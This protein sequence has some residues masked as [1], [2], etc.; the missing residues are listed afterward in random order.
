MLE[1]KLLPG[2]SVN[3]ISYLAPPHGNCAAF[4]SIAM[5]MRERPLG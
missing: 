2:R 3:V 5:R 4:Q 1:R